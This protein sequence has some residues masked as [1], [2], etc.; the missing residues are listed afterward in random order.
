M[1]SKFFQSLKGAFLDEEKVI[2]DI[3]K[4]IYWLKNKQL[5]KIDGN[6]GAILYAQ[7][8]V[9]SIA[10]NDSK[11]I[12]CVFTSKLEVAKL[13]EETTIN[14]YDTRTLRNIWK[15]PVKIW[16]SI[17]S[18]TIDDEKMVTITSKGFNIIDIKTG[19]KKW[20]R[21]EA[22]PL[23]K[24]IVPVSSGYLIVQDKFL[25][26][27][28]NKGKI[29]WDDKI[30]VSLSSKENPIHIIENQN[31]AIF[32]TPSKVNIVDIEDG[33]KLWSEDVVLN[34][35]S[36]LDR[37]LKISDQQF[38]V[39]DDT[40]NIRI[41]LFSENSFH[42]FDKNFTQKP[43]KVNGFEFKRGAP[44]LR[45][46]DNAYFLYK[47]NQYFLYDL[48]G[49]LRYKKMYPSIESTNFLGEAYYWTKRGF[50]TTTS[51]LGFI[52]NQVTQTLN[53]V[54]ISQDLGVLTNTTSTIYGTYLSY[55]NS[56]SNLTELNRLGLGSNIS[57]IFNRMKA[58]QENN[59]NFIVVSATERESKI[60]KLDI[61]SGSEEVIKKTSRKYS[62]FLLDQVE[63]QIYF[64]EKKNI[65]IEDLE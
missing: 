22:L 26:R 45:I 27:I 16:G 56:I 25:V 59:G 58:D 65:I 48:T 4:N 10:M 6:T 43:V 53:T 5:I 49:K 17:S 40:R 42:I 19:A 57:A 1:E 46:I 61:A 50:G 29:A 30:K 51:A 34:T 18:S 55:Q 13:H 12:L 9:N 35:A 52:P 20:K 41:P 31:E 47:D 24:K 8:D 3:Q 64:F 38:K 44:K 54:L 60:I 37:N 23:I 2:L 39:W 36:F 7:E 14:A 62:N 15:T 11:D 33:T 32:I 63:Q 28:N 21:S